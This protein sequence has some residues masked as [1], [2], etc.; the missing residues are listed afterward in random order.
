M[1]LQTLLENAV[2]HNQVGRD[3]PLAV[4]L[5]LA[6]DHVRVSNPRR[7]R[8][9]ALPTSGLGLTNLDERCRFVTGR[10]LRLAAATG[11]FVVEVPMVAA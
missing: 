2:K 10:A 9:S 8:A 7:P 11:D 6:G 3:A 1:G 5:D 4:R